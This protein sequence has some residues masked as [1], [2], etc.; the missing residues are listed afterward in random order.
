M[1][2]DDVTLTT[3]G[4]FNG[5]EGSLPAS[6]EA[7]YDYEVRWQAEVPELLSDAS[8]ARVVAYVLDITTGEVQN[9]DALRVGE[10]PTGGVSELRGSESP[11][12]LGATLE[13]VNV[14]LAA[15]EAYCLDI[16][17]VAGSRIGSL[18]G[19]GRGYEVLPYKTAPGIYI[20]TLTTAHT[21]TSVKMAVR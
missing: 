14:R 9:S 17:N 8:K 4:A 10:H 18:S 15:G 7:G 20:I 12:I 6:M 3:E 1:Y 11:V 21:R 2:Y 13:G 5:I 19:I 16:Y